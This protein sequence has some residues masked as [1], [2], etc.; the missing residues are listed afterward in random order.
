MTPRRLFGLFATAALAALGAAGCS[1]DTG[2][3]QPWPLDTDPIVFEDQFTGKVEF[4]AFG[5]SQLDALSVQTAEQYD[6]STCLRIRVPAPGGKYAGGAFVAR[7]ERDLSGYTA[8]TFW[9]KASRP[10]TVLKLGFGN[11][12]AGNL[13]YE[14]SVS[15]IQLTTTYKKIAIPIPLPAKLRAERGLFFFSAEP[16][17]DSGYD[18]YVDEVKFEN[19]PTITN[20][21]PV[22]TTRTLNTFAGAVSDVLGTRV[23]FSVEGADL[24]V[25][26]MPAYFTYAS[27]DSS[28]ATVDDGVIRVIGVGSATISAQLDTM[29]VA[30][31]VTVNA[32]EFT[33]GLA[34][35]PTVPAGN[36][37]SIFSNAYANR[38]VDKWSADW[39]E[40]DVTDLQ[41]YDND[42]KLYTNLIFAA[43]EFTSQTIDATAMG[44]FHMDIWIPTGTLFKVKLVDFGPDGAYNPPGSVSDDQESQI[45]FT[46]V[47]T[48]PL[49]AGTWIGL[50][51][52]LSSFT[53]LTTRAHLAQI[54]IEGNPG[55]VYV[56]NI[57]FHK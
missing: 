39:D 41:I 55:S 9:A 43:I 27:S 52:P 48:P 40:A 6:G 49:V 20:P 8:L 15:G 33:P 31:A 36:V 29:T 19:L 30:G 28:V 53:A 56:D 14:A 26:H 45:A 50:E 23:T 57:Y 13:K 11:D 17:G 10:V 5:N 22:M 54:V 32:G 2:S 46:P 44:Y 35:T 38:Y 25:S 3:L 18:I 47:S 7:Q 34:P 24:L 37:I 42:M 21:R 4:Y 16:Q 51:A 12:N 1:H